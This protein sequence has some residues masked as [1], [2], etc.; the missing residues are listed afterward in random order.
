MATCGL[1]VG[2]F[3]LLFHEALQMSLDSEGQQC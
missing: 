3:Y 2:Y 1:P